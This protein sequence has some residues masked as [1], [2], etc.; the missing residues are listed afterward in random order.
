MKSLTRSIFILCVNFTIFV[1]A[2]VIAIPEFMDFSLLS[3]IPLILIASGIFLRLMLFKYPY[4][5][6]IVLSLLLLLAISIFGI[7]SSAFQSAAIYKVMKL[8][9]FIM[10][11]LAFWS[12]LEWKIL[13]FNDIKKIATIGLLFYIPSSL[14]AA[15]SWSGDTLSGANGAYTLLWAFLVGCTLTTKRDLS[16][17]IL[18]FC[19][20][21][22]EFILFKRGVLLCLVIA[23]SVYAFLLVKDRLTIARLSGIIFLPMLVFIFIWIGFFSRGDFVALKL[24]DGSVGGRDIL[25]LTILNGILESSFTN[26]MF[27]HGAMSVEVMTGD[28]L[29]IRPDSEYGL[30]A[31]ND[32]LTLF[33]D[34]GL[35]S[36]IIFFIFHIL[37]YKKISQKTSSAA[38]IHSYRC[39]SGYF[40]IVVVSF[41]SEILFT[42]SFLFLAGLIAI[43]MCNTYNSNAAKII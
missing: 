36:V 41:V 18:L 27:G 5:N 32:W 26:F 40:A 6:G 35:L 33:Y 13:R 2:L 16:L 17:N 42:A 4:R 28:V 7:N 37:L 1:D 43:M 8:F 25:Y 21:A 24:S 38:L 39:M 14:Y 12:L 9:Y 34:F 10:I 11:I 15:L 31:H 30:Q 22:T 19:A 29:G 20:L 3:K 23:L